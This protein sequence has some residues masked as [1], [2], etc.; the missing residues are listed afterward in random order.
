[1][2]LEKNLIISVNVGRQHPD[3]GRIREEFEARKYRYVALDVK[4]EHGI[5]KFLV[6]H[7]PNEVCA[8]ELRGARGW[9]TNW[10][11]FSAGVSALMSI[12]P[13]IPTIN[14]FSMFEWLLEK[15]VYLPDVE[16]AGGPIIRS[17]L[18]EPGQEVDFLDIINRL[19]GSGVIKPSAGS[20][21]T[22]I[23]FIH[24]DSG[25]FKVT[26]PQMGNPEPLVE[27]MT[28]EKLNEYMNLYRLDT[29]QT[30]MVQEFVDG[31]EI[32]AVFV[33]G[34]PHFIS[35]TKASNLVAHED[36]GGD[37]ILNEDPPSS[38]VALA[39]QIYNA[40]PEKIRDP[41]YFRADMIY[42]GEE[43]NPVLLEIESGSARLFLEE[44]DRILDYVEAVINKINA[45][46]NPVVSLAKLQNPTIPT[47][48]T[49]PGNRPGKT[50]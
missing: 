50:L 18:I 13:G 19:G 1:M 43:Q 42:R 33:G 48:P 32:S 49:R 24:S 23:L 30:I 28:P 21:A 6:N 12:I 35:R 29:T 3:W 40:L 17:E 22:G 11:V 36:F 9:Q 8:I 25:T 31:L 2:K 38:I 27:S 46:N 45:T 44:S 26:V 4:E 20:R 5:E 7:D 16:K 34:K 39:Y 10:E 37:N 47:P 41:A 15:T 14:D